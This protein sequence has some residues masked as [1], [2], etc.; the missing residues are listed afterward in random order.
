[1]FIFKNDTELS[2]LI[3]R[4]IEKEKVYKLF[5]LLCYFKIYQKKRS[6]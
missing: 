5:A 2:R 6:E 1:M 3:E 4:K